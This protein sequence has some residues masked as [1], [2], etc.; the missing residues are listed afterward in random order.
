MKSEKNPFARLWILLKNERQDILSVYF[1]AILSGF[2]QLIVPIGVQAIIG[3]VLGATMVT[4]IYV[5]IVLV[6]VAVLSA[7]LVQ[8]NQM[9]INEKIQQKIFVNFALQFV[10]VIPRIDLK[11]SMNSY[12]PEKINRFFDTLTVQKGLT[13]LILEIPTALIQIFLGVLLLALYHPV[14]IALGAI[15]IVALWLII[16]LSG[17]NGI[18]TSLNE[19][20]EK[21]A[22]VAWFEEMAKAVKPFKNSQDSSMDVSRTDA[23]L[24]KY[25]TARTS[26]FGILLLQYRTL[27]VL[28]V[29]ITTML[30][31]AGVYLLINQQLNIGEFI[32]A[33]IVILM[34]I[35]S[36]EKIIKSLESVYDVVTGL[37]KL[38]N[39]IES[40]TDLDGS[41]EFSESSIGIEMKNVGF[42]FNGDQKMLLDI[43]LKIPAGAVVS[44]QGVE[45]S[46]KSTLLKILSNLYTSYSGNVIV[47]GIPVRNYQLKSIRRQTGIYFGQDDLFSGTVLDNINLGRQEITGE[48][49]MKMASKIGMAHFLENLPMG[50]QTYVHSNAALLP[51]STKHKI[52]ILRSLCHNPK[53][54]VMEDPFNGLREGVKRPLMDYLLGQSGKQTI[55]VATADEE[56]ANAADFVMTLSNGKAT[57]TTNKRHKDNES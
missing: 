29:I 2:L 6:V 10:E 12:L 36:T 13:K 14:F 7:G 40:E 33:E 18:A 44:L 23:H 50:F 11:H 43:N 24:V 30:L 27:I 22:L 20:N 41:I 17:T 48:M 1:Y 52:L 56:F 45:G 57:L 42:T 47:N 21:Y 55:I 49:V 34:I 39:I 31:T 28:K 4:S 19:S 26:H 16:K 37:V 15:L 9:K 54:V 25:I 38:A 53:L 3:F 5:L 46:G 8:V 32:A 51:T 35:G